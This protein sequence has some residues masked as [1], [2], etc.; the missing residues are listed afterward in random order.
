MSDNALSIDQALDLLRFARD[1]G[2]L[3]RDVAR[4]IYDAVVDVKL[5]D[6]RLRAENAELRARLAAISGLAMSLENDFPFT[7]EGED[8]PS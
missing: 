5:D 3:H 7:E 2:V 1:T 6:E 8:D 4:A